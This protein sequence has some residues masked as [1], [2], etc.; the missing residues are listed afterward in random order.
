MTPQMIAK[1]I[2]LRT[3]CKAKGEDHRRRATASK[4]RRFS[5]YAFALL[6]L[7]PMPATAIGLEDSPWE[8]A[9]DAVSLDPLLLYAVALTESG[10]REGQD[11]LAP[12]PWA[13][14]V[15][16]QPYFPASRDEAAQILTLNKGKSIDVG[17]MQVNTRWHGHRVT[18]HADLL[19]PATNLFVGAAILKEALDSEPGDLT[20]G[21]GRYHSTTRERGRSYARTVVEFY[22]HL[23]HHEFTGEQ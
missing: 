1:K 10:R 7:L 22:R 17:L 4:V 11:Q 9:A 12:W 23:M 2:P 20:T 8:H 19:E 16:G 5:F 18:A 6:Y 15:E 13:L 21:L 14:N 3:T